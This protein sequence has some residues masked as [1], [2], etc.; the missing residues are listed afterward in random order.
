MIELNK[1][2][3]VLPEVPVQPVEPK[4]PSECTLKISQ[5]EAPVLFQE[6][7]GAVPAL[8]VHVFKPLQKIFAVEVG[9]GVGVTGQPPFERPSKTLKL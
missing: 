7:V 5:D 6:M 4:V 2:G 9:V 8:M 3:L 1:V